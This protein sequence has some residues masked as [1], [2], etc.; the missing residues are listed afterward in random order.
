MRTF[1]ITLAFALA[2]LGP[3]ACS[4]R[5]EGKPVSA[6]SASYTV[7]DDDGSQ[8][9]DA[10]N[11]ARGDVRLV[12][13]V[14][15]TCAVCL[16][17]LADV[18][19]DL[20][21]TTTNPRLQTFIV[22]EPV[23]GGKASDIAPAATLVSNAH[24]RAFWNADGGFGHLYATAVDLR[25][26]G[27]PVNAWDVWTVYGSDATWKGYAPP[28]PALLMHQL[29]TLDNPDYRR[30]DGKL[31]AQTARALLAKLPAPNAAP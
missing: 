22:F 12:L 8:L 11:Q 28:P 29:P 23:I 17:G 13:L 26:H 24:V 25:R 27:K 10:F 5:S 30:L 14:D 4:Q 6:A 1:A 16:R 31:F 2:L 3:M 20:L 21:A 7:L 15:P 18:N 9:R 19:A